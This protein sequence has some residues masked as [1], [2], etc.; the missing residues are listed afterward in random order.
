MFPG[1][2]RKYSWWRSLR[3]CYNIQRWC[4]WWGSLC[5]AL[6]LY[7]FIGYCIGMELAYL[8]FWH[9]TVVTC[10]I[11]HLQICFRAV[12]F[13]RL[14]RGRKNVVKMFY[15]TCNHSLTVVSCVYSHWVTVNIVIAAK[16]TF[17]RFT[18]IVKLSYNYVIAT[19]SVKMSQCCI[20]NS[21]TPAANVRV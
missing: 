17:K 1:P 21:G 2:V 18:F 6:L 9:K 11:N 7:H 20:R 13:P 3:W 15:F 5:A 12:D 4:Y 14:C 8:S 16:L 19:Y 10:K